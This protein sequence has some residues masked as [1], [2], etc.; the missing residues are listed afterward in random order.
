MDGRLY[1]WFNQLADRT[2][3]AHGVM[4]FYANDGIVIFGVLIVIV[5]VLARQRNDHVAVAA[6]AWSGGAALVALLIGQLVGIPIDRARPYD[7]MSNVH[8]L[9]DRTTDFSFP[10]DHALVAGSVAVGLLFASRRW[11]IVACAAAMLMAFARV[12]VGAH[13]PGDVAAGLAIGAVIATI[14]GYLV[15]PFLARLVDS[16]VRTPLRPLL[17]S[18]GRAAA[19]VDSVDE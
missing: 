19:P 7:A 3:W 2:S 8:V 10:S 6:T 18:A 17:T 16:L 12:Y 1:R 14:G 15:V 5:F 13:Y 4:T 11:G 9:V